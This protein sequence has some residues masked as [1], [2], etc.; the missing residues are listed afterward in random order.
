LSGSR[1]NGHARRWVIVAG[2]GGVIVVV[3]AVL[4]GRD[5]LPIRSAD[6]RTEEI[7]LESSGNTYQL[8]ATIN[9][10]VKINFTLD[11]GASDVQV[12]AE[13][14]LTLLTSGT[15]SDGDFLG[16]QTYKLADGST[17]PSAEFKLRDM[18]VGS[19][20]LTNVIA[21]VGPVGSS[22]LLGQ[23]FLSRLGSWT[24]DNQQRVLRVER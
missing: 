17:L 5:Q 20:H 23:S 19:H 10:T 7:K 12:P 3:F 16:Y 1:A 11:T 9:D 8:K 15:L 22:P 14:A 6:A 24:I 2:I 21:S 13:V 18:E 4:I